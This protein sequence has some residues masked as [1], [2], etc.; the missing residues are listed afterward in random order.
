MFSICQ[1]LLFIELLLNKAIFCYILISIDISG[2][3][4][5][6]NGP[7]R[8]GNAS[9]P[10]AQSGHENRCRA[11]HLAADGI[12]TG[13]SRIHIQPPGAS[14]HAWR[15]SSVCRHQSQR[16]AFALHTEGWSP[17]SQGRFPVPQEVP[18]EAVRSPPGKDE[19]DFPGNRGSEN[20]GN[21]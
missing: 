17:P 8:S 21:P 6:H 12:Q 18:D 9:W 7:R 4:T 14:S 16:R 15:K 1:L 20:P 3:G 11:A 19:P 5:P 2:G 10:N 13:L